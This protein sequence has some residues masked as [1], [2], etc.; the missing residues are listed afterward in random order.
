A[1]GYGNGVVGVTQ[2]ISAQAVCPSAQLAFTAEY[3]NGVT[4]SA[5]VVYADINGNATIYWTPTIFGLVTQATIGSTCSPVYLG[6]ANIGQTLT[7]TT[8][9]TPNNAQVGV[10]T[11]ITVTVQ[12]NS[13]SAYSPTGQ[14]VVKDVNGAKLQTMGLTPGPGNCQGYAYYWWTPP[15]CKCGIVSFTA[16]LHNC[17]T[18]RHPDN[19][20]ASNHH[21]N[22]YPAN[23]DCHGLSDHRAGLSWLHIEW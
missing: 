15:A 22:W 13:P 8:I 16:G 23:L 10:A 5:P 17:H 9:S 6:G 3:S 20:D 18:E 14:V 11:K 1:T 4:V 2:T 19:F 21:D 12:S 7:T